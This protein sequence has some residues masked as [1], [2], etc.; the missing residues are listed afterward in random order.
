MEIETPKSDIVKYSDLIN[1][2]IFESQKTALESLNRIDLDKAIRENRALPEETPEGFVLRCIGRSFNSEKI[3]GF[4]IGVFIG[5]SLVHRAICANPLSRSNKLP[6]ITLDNQINYTDKI[7]NS[8][9]FMYKREGFGNYL[10]SSFDV[11]K[12]LINSSEI[13]F[14]DTHD[15]FISYMNIVDNLELPINE[16]ACI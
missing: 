7:I 12:K 15:G 10:N 14:I 16:S 2:D 1:W 9:S 8:L 13:G 5:S 11:I 3:N 6:E 4:E